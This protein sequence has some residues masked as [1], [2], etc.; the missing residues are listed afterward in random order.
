MEISFRK[1]L[2]FSLF[3]LFCLFLICPASSAQSFGL[4]FTASTATPVVLSKK[5]HVVPITVRLKGHKRLVSSRRKPVN[6]SII[7]DRSTSMAGGAIERAK[8]SAIMAINMLDREDIVSV[9]V[10]DNSATVIV[11]ATKLHDKAEA[12]KAIRDISVTGMTALFGGVSKGAGE[13]RKF[14]ESGYVNRAVLLSDGQANVGPSSPTELGELG[15]SLAREGISVSTIGLGLN[16]NEDLMAVLAR[17]SEGNHAFVEHATDLPRIFKHEFG[18][19]LNVVAKDV[20]IDLEC[21]LGVRP[22]RVLGRRA[23]IRGQKVSL[24]LNEVYSEQEKDIIIEVEAPEG[25]SGEIKNLAE[26]RVAHVDALSA[27]N[28]DRA[29]VLRLSYADTSEEVEKRINKDA[30]VS[31]QRQLVNDDRDSAIALKDQG[32]KGEARKV[33]ELSKTKLEGLSSSLGIPQLRELSKEVQED[34]E[35]MGAMGAKWDAKRK[36]MRVEQNRVNSGQTWK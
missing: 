31:Y 5:R 33:L 27:V 25:E 20:R 29:E 1:G 17:M 7:I 23:E 18:D 3:F 21:A 14:I 2:F 19:I 35:G 15:A 11:P 16:Y 32:K 10:Y 6:V 28:S 30:Y 22:V 36:A 12:I 13:L 8:E 4:S 9:V 34:A 26:V 24:R